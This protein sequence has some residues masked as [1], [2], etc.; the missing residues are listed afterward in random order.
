LERLSEHIF[1]VGSGGL[2]KIIYFLGAYLYIF[3]CYLFCIFSALAL[4]THGLYFQGEMAGE[5]LSRIISPKLC[6][7]LQRV[8]N[9]ISAETDVVY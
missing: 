3:E 6:V 2:W 9:C 1:K 5:A 8:P 7:A 4:M